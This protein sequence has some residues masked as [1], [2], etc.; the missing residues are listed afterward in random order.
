MARE[1]P[2]GAKG[3]EIADLGGLQPN[4]VPAASLQPLD[5]IAREAPDYL[6]WILG[7]DF[8]EDAKQLVRDALGG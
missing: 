2:P 6:K 1:Q 4:A 5:G 8:P 7:T 3:N